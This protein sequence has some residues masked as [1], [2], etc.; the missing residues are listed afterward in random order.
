MRSNSG[1][2]EVWQVV[3]KSTSRDLPREVEIL[4]ATLR[5]GQQCRGVNFTLDARIRIAR[6][7]D[8]LG[9]HFI[10]AGWPAASPKDKEV[11]RRLSEVGLRNARV[12]AFTM[13]RRKDVSVDKDPSLN[14][15]LE[16]GVDVA[17]VVG[18]SWSLH[19]R[20]VLRT[21]L[22][23][24]LDIVS[25]SIQ[26]LRDHGLEVIFDAEHFFD[27]YK[28]DPE[29]ALSVLKAAEGAGART[30]VLADTNGGCLPHEV[31]EIVA[32][33]KERVRRPIGI[34]AHNDSGNAV[35]NTIMAVISGATHVQTTVNGI[36]ERAGNA[37]LCQVIPNLELKLG[38]RAIKSG[39]EGLKK[40]T[41]ISNMVYELS[42]LPRNRYQPYVG[43]YAFA[44]KAGLHI[45]AIMKNRRAYEHI[46]PELVGNKRL[47]TVSD[48]SG[49]SALIASLSELLGIELDK[50]SEDLSAILEEVK[51]LGLR[52][53]NLDDATGTI[54]LIFLK[55]FGRYVPKFEILEWASLAGGGRD[56]PK[57][58]GLVKVKIGDKIM[59][60]GG[61]GVGPVHAIDVALRK[62]LEQEYPEL[63]KVKLIDYRVILPEAERDTASLVR[64]FIKFTNGLE[65]WTTT[66]T[67]TN[68]IEASFDALIQGLDYY[69]QLRNLRFRKAE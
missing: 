21:T 16:C 64:V 43:E 38:I 46:D 41:G 49:K 4:D 33:V 66:A 23:D 52:E 10:E 15:I 65:T 50:K 40:L 20:E 69:L 37:D 7:L 63:K 56:G 29:Y 9:V 32:E 59:V 5:E 24:N 26:Y 36:G 48:L 58:Y 67:S 22:E 62:A 18:K 35:A 2:A 30:L 39:L 57:A 53:V 60:E 55:Y 44:H 47:L 68:I 12:A 31:A 28:E 14:E 61:E 1:G 13:T 42:G 11:F 45:D 34:H 51:Q 54:S 19:V 25:D 8:E 27:G 17:V 3:D 6:E